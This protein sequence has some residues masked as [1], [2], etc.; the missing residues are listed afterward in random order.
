MQKLRQ[1]C[2][3]KDYE[4][5]M[6]LVQ[7]AVPEF[8]KSAH[9]FRI[10]IDL[11]FVYEGITELI[12]Q[13]PPMI[14]P[15]PRRAP[16]F[17]NLNRLAWKR[18]RG[19][20][21][22]SSIRWQDALGYSVLS[23]WLSTTERAFPL[24]PSENISPLVVIVGHWRSGTSLLHE[25]LSASGVFTYPTTFACL[26]AHTFILNRGHHRQG[27]VEMSRP[28]DNMIIR[29]DLPQEDEFA[30]FSLG[31]P[32]PYEAMLFPNG[33][34]E[35]AVRSDPDFYTPAELDAWTRA[36]IRFCAAHKDGDRPLLLKSPPHSLKS[37]LIR[38]LCPD[39]KFIRIVRDPRSVF[40]SNRVLW[41]SLWA[42]YGLASPLGSG[43][44]DSGIL[45]S[46]IHFDK[47]MERDLDRDA[48]AV[49]IRYEDLLAD[50][51]GTVGAI[52]NFLTLPPDTLSHLADRIR[53]VGSYSKR[54]NDLT[55]TEIVMVQS[56]C[57]DAMI[58]Q[59]YLT[60]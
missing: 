23:T 43:D 3:A 21:K 54:K 29:D 33:V 34:G 58:R 22:E 13:K 20:H 6:R 28:M 30:L 56:A 17:L 12:L 60:L 41:H 40:E 46:M 32:S 57:A 2:T 14:T 35:L 26:N 27:G 53:A 11:D 36:F 37:R 7:I 18:S 49:T 10:E 16:R 15:L 24:L 38:S 4:R 19:R 5:A 39:A 48:M 31:A 1:A 44:L 47:V 55:P 52:L 45:R 51:E 59:G 8:V 50:T 42:A 9:Q 25:L